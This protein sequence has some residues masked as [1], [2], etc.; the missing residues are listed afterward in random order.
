MFNMR[1]VSKLFSEKSLCQVW[2][3][4]DFVLAWAC[5]GTGLE[6]KSPIVL[7]LSLEKLLWK[8]KGYGQ[9]SW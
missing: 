5:F 2:N 6:N 1:C 7:F 9:S 3:Q 8:K 4:E